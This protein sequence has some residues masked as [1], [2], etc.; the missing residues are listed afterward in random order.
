[1]LP[2]YNQ[3]CIHRGNLTEAQ[4][5]LNRA[6]ALAVRSRGRPG[7]YE[8]VRRHLAEITLAVKPIGT[9]AEIA[10]LRSHCIAVAARAADHDLAE[11]L[12]GSFF[13][14]IGETLVT[15]AHWRMA[16]GACNFMKQNAAAAIPPYHMVNLQLTGVLGE[17]CLREIAARRLAFCLCRERDTSSAVLI[18]RRAGLPVTL[19]PARGKIQLKNLILSP[20][21]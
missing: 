10:E 2:H 1:V 16:Q 21:P 13:N 9:R 15:G 17:P 3:N 7:S 6:Y 4:H 12:N 14:D 18:L 5:L 20:M 11:R 8:R 19:A